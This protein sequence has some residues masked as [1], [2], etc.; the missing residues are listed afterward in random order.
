MPRNDTEE[1]KQYK[2][3]AKLE[4][5]TMDQLINFKL[6][7]VLENQTEIILKLTKE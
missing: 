5:V 3:Q 1:E 4:I 7:Q 6:D 2:E